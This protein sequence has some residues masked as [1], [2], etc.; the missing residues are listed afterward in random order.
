MMP[1]NCTTFEREGRVYY[2][3]KRMN[4]LAF[5]R[6]VK[7]ESEV[8]LPYM[9]GDCMMFEQLRNADG[10]RYESMESAIEAV[11]MQDYG[12]LLAEIKKSCGLTVEAAD[13]ENPT[14]TESASSEG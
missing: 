5:I 13:A 8:E 9:P 12:D 2:F 4:R 6:L 11:D 14:T 7:A 1:D 10:S 3:E